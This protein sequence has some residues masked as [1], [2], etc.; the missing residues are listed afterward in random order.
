MNVEGVLLWGFIAT[1][2]LESVL[3]GSQALRLTRMS[4]PL[5]LG[6]TVTAD[7]DR[8]RLWGLAMHFVNG[9]AFSFVYAL[10]F[11]T[12][13]RST[14]WIGG[15]TGAAHGFVMLVIVV[16]A[17][18]AV[19]HRMAS[20]DRQ[21]GLTPLLEPPGLLALNYG[22]GT[23]LVTTAAHVLYGVILGSFYQLAG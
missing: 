19:H 17:L 11:E 10:M 15:L 14:W 16:P 6:T 3:A 20:E 5:M 23:P 2:A 22:R 13:R 1:T 9:I 4:I 7:W 21:A 8:A 18:P 12:W